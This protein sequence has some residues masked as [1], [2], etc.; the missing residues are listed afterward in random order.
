MRTLLRAGLLV[1]ALALAMAGCAQGP[2]PA[3]SAPPDTQAP[4]ETALP[5]TIKAWAAAARAKDAAKFVS[6]YTR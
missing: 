1:G 3:P 6:F 5:A 2:A 4:D